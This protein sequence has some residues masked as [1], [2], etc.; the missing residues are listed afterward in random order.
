MQ[1]LNSNAKMEWR[2]LPLAV[3]WWPFAWTD[4]W[5]VDLAP[6]YSWAMAAMPSR[7]AMWIVARK[8]ELDAATYERLVAKA[9]ALGFETNKLIR[10]RHAAQ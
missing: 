2:F 6:D 3:A 10:T 7:E 4:Y 9:R 8:P 1:D 5:I